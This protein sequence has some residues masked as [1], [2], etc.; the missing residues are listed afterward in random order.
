MFCPKCGMEN[1]D[2]GKFC[3]SCRA[4]LSNVLAVV[5]GS[6]PEESGLTVE[7]NPAELYSTGV[8]N[9]IL[10]AGFFVTSLVIFSLPGDTVFWLLAMIPAFCLI[11]SAARR[12][13]KAEAMKKQREVKATVVQQ[14]TF[15]SSQP[16]KELPP[17]RVDYISPK[18]SIY[19]TDGLVGEPLSVT[20]L[21]TRHLEM[22]L[23]SET[24]TLPK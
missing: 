23:E 10:G 16:I 3:R 11:A 13:I 17:T 18:K 1:P 7:D 14:P 21:T 24:M 9:A 19:E 8:R 22:D 5:D 20:E 15:S 2:N 6:L 12:L 4:N